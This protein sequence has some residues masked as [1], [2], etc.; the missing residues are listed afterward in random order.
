MRG[1]TLV[2]ALAGDGP[3]PLEII[4]ERL[5]QQLQSRIDD[6]KFCTNRA[7]YENKGG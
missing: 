3:P 6:L 1:R 4:V 5:V 7:E 2:V